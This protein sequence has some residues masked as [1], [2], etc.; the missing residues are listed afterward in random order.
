MSNLAHI[1]TWFETI[2]PILTS[3]AL[4]AGGTWT[5]Y[6]YIY[7]RERLP[8][9]EL[10]INVSSFSVSEWTYLLAKVHV[11]NIGQLLL[12]V[13]SV[14]IRVQRVSPQPDY[15]E[16]KYHPTPRDVV[17]DWPMLAQKEKEFVVGDQEL[18]PNEI[19]ETDFDFLLPSNIK[20]VKITAYIPN[21]RK[22]K[23]DIGWLAT[24]IYILD[25]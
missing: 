9:A 1:K 16:P 5:Y 21:I 20:I 12:Q 22:A 3:I 25:D 4:I 14:T 15:Y 18:E 11:K 23:Q 17:F 6:N 19:H 8:R 24:S 10:T 13:K 7:K 2:Q